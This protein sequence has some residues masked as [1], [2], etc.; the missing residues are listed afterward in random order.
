M[1]GDPVHS[2]IRNPAGTQ[3]KLQDLVNHEQQQHKRHVQ[4]KVTDEAHSNEQLFWVMR[5][6]IKRKA[7]LGAS[8]VSAKGELRMDKVRL[9]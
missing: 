5:M 7:V 6:Y 2:L 9:V 1:T 8:I 4:F 3:C